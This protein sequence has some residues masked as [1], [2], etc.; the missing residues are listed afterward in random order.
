[1]SSILRLA[2]G[3]RIR[4]CGNAVARDAGASHRIGTAAAG[5][6]AVPFDGRNDF[7][8]TLLD[9]T[10]MLQGSAAPGEKDDISWCRL[11][12]P[13]LPLVFRLEPVCLAVYNG[14]L[15]DGAALKIAALIGA[16]GNEAGALL[17]AG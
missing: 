14:K 5:V 2:P 7:A 4:I 1:M 15:R 8:I 6:G 13:A 11:I 12:R 3:R 9:D 10:D 17:H 16:P